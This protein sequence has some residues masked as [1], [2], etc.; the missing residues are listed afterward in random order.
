[1]TTSGT[2]KLTKFG[3]GST[4]V[5]AD[6]ANSMFG[7]LYGSGESVG[8]D[9]TD[10]RLTGHIHDGQH[11]DGH[12]QKID[13]VDH[14]SGKLT[15]INLEDEAVYKN[16]VGKFETQSNAIPEFEEIDGTT[17]YY[18]DLS[19]L[20]AE[21]SSITPD[22]VFTVDYTVPPNGVIRP[23][24]D[25]YY[26]SSGLSFVFGSSQMDDLDIGTVGDIRF[27]FDK[28]LGAFRAGETTN[29]SW[30]KRGAHSA[31]FGLDNICWASGSFSS[32]YKNAIDEYATNSSSFGF[33][34]RVETENSFAIGY[35]SKASAIDGEFTHASSYI[36]EIGDAQVSRFTLVGSKENTSAGYSNEPL[37]TDGIDLTRNYEIDTFCSYIVK[38]NVLARKYGST[39]TAAFEIA[40]VIEKGN[41]ASTPSVY[42]SYKNV[43]YQYSP[44]LLSTD[45]SIDIINDKIRVIVT[46]TLAIAQTLNWIA[47][48]EIVKVKF[49]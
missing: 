13:L 32:G 24:D 11:L 9:E 45:A 40:A 21:I 8:L 17:Y 20:R 30:D 14:V 19:E 37:S 2:S 18:L 36:N 42:I 27:F 46:D 48:V 43:L 5:T 35:G 33:E 1:M 15:N 6:F 26:S 29:D 3:S 12:S 38:A 16:N 7:G 28:E 41:T 25:D 10:V 4:I 34:N 39:Q 44:N 49:A 23:V 47:S 31:A 22:S